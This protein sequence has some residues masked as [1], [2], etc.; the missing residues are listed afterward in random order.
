MPG[1]DDRELFDRAIEEK[2]SFV[3]GSAFFVNGEGHQFARLAFSGISH[4][5]IEAGILRLA[6]AVRRSTD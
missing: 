5:Q 4:E 3:L 1:V 6:A 2:V